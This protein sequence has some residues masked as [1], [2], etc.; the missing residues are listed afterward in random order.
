M[1]LGLAGKVVLITGGSGSIG[2][3]LARAFAAEGAS[4]AVTYHRNESGA[5]RVA[6]DVR[7]LGG[8]ATT[9]RYDLTDRGSIQAAFD[10][11]AAEWGGVDVVIVNASAIPGTKV[12]PVAFEDIPVEE[13]QPFLRADVEGSFHTVQAALPWMKKQGWGRIVFISANI[14]QRGA[15]GD[16]AFV[17]SKMALHGLSR[18]LATELAPQGIL[19]NVVAPGPTVTRGFL[20]RVPEE[21]RKDLAGKSPEQI[22]RA[23]N[24]GRPAGHIS[25]PDD[26]AGLV[27]YFASTVN[28]NVTG[29]VVHVAGGN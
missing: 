20:A 8:K 4:V 3:H 26:I 16:E 21:F 10:A 5:Y 2:G 13:W 7:A 25:T 11:V 24:K 29:S 23:L 12:H 17:A 1:D 18:T 9:V 6:Q 15:A 27:L 22:K 28:G 14:V 19:V